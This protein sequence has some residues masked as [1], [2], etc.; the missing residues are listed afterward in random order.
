VRLAFKHRRPIAVSGERRKRIVSSAAL[1]ILGSLLVLMVSAAIPATAATDGP[2]TYEAD[3]M[4]T[5]LGAG[6]TAPFILGLGINAS[7]DNIAATGATFGASGT[8]T[9]T[10]IGP[11]V[12]G[13]NQTIFSPTINVSLT[14]KIG[15]T[16]GTATGSFTYTHTFTAQNNPGR[17]IMNVSWASGATT[18][19]AAAGTFLATDAGT[20]ADPTF[21]AGPSGGGIDPQS[22]IT[23]VA[24][25]GSSATIS[26]ATTAAAGPV[27]IG[28]GKNLTFTD[29]AFA[30]PAAAFTTNGVP[31]GNANIGI[32]EVDTTSLIAFGGGL[33]VPF[34]T[35]P[36]TGSASTT[37][38]L[39][40]G[41]DAA[42]TAGPAQFGSA[43]PLL[44][45]GTTT[46]L[47]LAS[48]GFISQPNTTPKITPPPAAH[49]I[50]LG[51]VTTTAAPTTVA[52][53]TVAPTTVA[54]TT[55]APTTV[56][57]TTVAP[58]TVAPTT[59]APTTVAPTTVAP[60]TVAPTTVA[61]TTVAPTTTISGSTTTTTPAGFPTTKAECKKGGW[62]QFGF[63]NQGQ[64]I[65]FVNHL[66]HP[67]NPPKPEKSAAHAKSINAHLAD[68][69]RPQTAGGNAL[70]ALTVGLLLFGMGMLLPHRRPRR[71]RA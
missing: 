20:V 56:A 13:A 46:P 8:A 71:R 9:F 63:K 69:V 66:N 19:T 49:A 53:T 55:V 22:M 6:Q 52:P 4:G 38:C 35:G 43:A 31:G 5:G 60:T 54:P 16:D 44:P 68:F 33:V 39:L 17:Q 48:G 27:T 10:L 7:P 25:D 36:G 37:L 14:D 1:A 58:T 51:E 70:L 15:S 26:V 67:P 3:C 59:V 65:K 11:V 18:L 32:T 12:A 62:K 21:V 50:L 30:T 42:S 28:T 2:T 57:P 40:T 45:V 34:G 64:C 61:P 47:V 41:F 29:A 24:A 23:A